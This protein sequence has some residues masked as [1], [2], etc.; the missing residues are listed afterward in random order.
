MT[1]DLRELDRLER[2][3][4]ALRYAMG[5][6]YFSG[7]TSDPPKGAA[8]RGEA[9]ATLGG[10]CHRLLCSD[11]TAALLD[12]LGK[13]GEGLDDTAAAQ[14]RVLRRDRARET[15]VPA[16]V[17]EEFTRLTV[18]SSDVWHRAKVAND[19]E[20]FEPYLDR[21]VD[22]MREIAAYKDPSRDP[23]DVWLDEF[24]PGAS[25]AFYDEFF[26]AVKDCVVPLVDAVRERG[27]QPDRS[28]VEGTFDENAQWELGRDVIELEGCDMDAM[29]LA[30]TEHPFSDALASG[31]AFIAT[32]IY[33]DDVTSNVF[34]MLHEG[35]HAMYEQGVDPAYDYTSLR[36]GTSMGIHEAQSRFFENYVGRSEAFAPQLLR[37]MSRRFPG[38]FDGVNPRDLYL[39]TNRAEPSLVRTE[40]DELT[41]P[42]H[43][44][45]RYEIEQLL[46][47][48][49]ATAADVP[50][51][52]S[53][54]Y[55][56]YLG[57]EVPDH[58]RGALQDTHWSDGSFGYFPTYAL[59]S[60]YGAQFRDRMVS[61]GMDFEGLVAAGDLSPIREWL[62]GRI[63][64][65]GRSKDPAELVESACG[66]P[67]DPG[68]YTNYLVEKFSVI[69]GLRGRT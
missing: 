58:T 28:C 36:G 60:A 25:R 20:S 37:L 61:E 2:H 42:L 47:S 44:L 1:N 50:G 39:A 27:W 14:V 64:R 69:Y 57:V 67:F 10:E 6:I 55:R 22:A 4:F 38:R 33:P 26:S 16:D 66:E 21:V 23:Y 53:D 52:W 29:V 9:L 46:F 18:E 62:R 45:V 63:W 34:S 17:A 32:H 5:G 65:W 15:D 51:L 43:V 40:A 56:R 48:G 8:A 31:H 19:W 11:E 49:E 13:R 59:G 12:R 41:Y 35:G 68:H 54:A 7:E 30:R 24:E 3:L